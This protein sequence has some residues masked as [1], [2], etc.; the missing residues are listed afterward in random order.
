MNGATVMRMCRTAD[1]GRANESNACVAAGDV[2]ERREVFAKT[3]VV[4]EVGGRE[5][6]RRDEPVPKIGTVPS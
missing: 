5:S 1:V 6:I 4:T 2:P 3:G